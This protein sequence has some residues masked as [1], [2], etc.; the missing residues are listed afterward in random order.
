MNLKRVAYLVC[1][2][3]CC[4]VLFALA[5]PYF[6]Q[7]F[8]SH[9]V[10]AHPAALSP[11][12]QPTPLPPSLM[13]NLGR[14]VIAVRST[15]TDVFVSWRLLGTDPPDTSFN[16]YRSTGAGSP[17]LLNTEPLTGPTHYVDSAADLTQ[18]NTYFV[19]PII[20]GVEQS[21]STSFTLPAAVPVQQFLRVPLQ[22][23]APEA[24]LRLGRITL[25][26]PTISASAILTVTAN[27]S[28]SSNGTPQTRKTTRRADSP[29][30]STLMLTNW[31]GLD[32]GASTWAATFA[33]APTTRSSWSMTSMETA[34]P[35][36]PARLP[37]G[38]STAPAVS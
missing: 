28:S 4:G 19:R 24:Q 1:A 33:P 22:V 31:T 20:F 14:G 29:A 5:Q 10:Y 30:T 38:P 8:G 13:E 27:M 32:S 34:K 16:L 9:T 23:P 36:S 26:V 11:V 18:A 35:K 12:G 21:P 2:L 37:M 17:V 25:T 3:F 15:S 6:L 7:N